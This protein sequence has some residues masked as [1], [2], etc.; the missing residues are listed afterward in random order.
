M[1]DV[2]AHTPTAAAEIAVPSYEVL[3]IE[4]QQ[5][6]QRLLAS[7]QQRLKQDLEQLDWLKNRLKNIPLN[8]VSIREAKIKTLML[9]HKLKALDPHAVLERGF[10]VVRQIDE[11]IVRD[12][13]QLN[14]E[15]EL[16]IQLAQG[17][18]KVKVTEIITD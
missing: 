7:I 17:S 12:V 6:K 8:A 10:S 16:I 1:A 14:E 18:I 11:Q 15:Q 13:E 3:K 9:K 5:R 4:H 2:N